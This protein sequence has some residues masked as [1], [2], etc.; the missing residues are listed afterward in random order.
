M[1]PLLLDT[2]AGF[3]IRL[4]YSESGSLS[5]PLFFLFYDF[6]SIFHSVSNMIPLYLNVYSMY[7][8]YLDVVYG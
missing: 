5:L 8:K 7:L 2:F 1:L 3:G 4:M 6:N